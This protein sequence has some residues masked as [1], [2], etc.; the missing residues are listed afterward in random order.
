NRSIDLRAGPQ[1]SRRTVIGGA[2]VLPQQEGDDSPAKVA[3]I[4]QYADGDSTEYRVVLFEDGEPPEDGEVV[5]LGT[6]P[7]E[8]V[9]TDTEGGIML[10]SAGSA[11]AGYDVYVFDIAGVLGDAET[12][13]RI[14]DTSDEETDV[15]MSLDGTVWGHRSTDDDGLGTAIL[16]YVDSGQV[17]RGFF[18]IALSNVRYDMKDPSVAGDGGSLVFV[19][20]TTSLDGVERIVQFFT[21]GGGAVLWAGDAL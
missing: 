14:P 16:Y 18:G 20:D 10:V 9:A 4:E 5:F 17:F 6:T 15:S 8:S 11:A 3:T 13:Y 2:S 19:F 7:I 21:A 12:V 1:A